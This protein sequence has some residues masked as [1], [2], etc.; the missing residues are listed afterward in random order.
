[1]HTSN[2]DL[3]ACMI[4]SQSTRDLDGYNQ[5]DLITGKRSSKRNEII[6]FAEATP[7]AIPLGDF[8]Y[9]FIDGTVKPDWPILTNLQRNVVDSTILY[10][11]YYILYYYYYTTTLYYYYIRT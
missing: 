1:M 2:L 8:K 9:R 3:N 11:Y 10:Y 4:V 7:G 5:M 6:C